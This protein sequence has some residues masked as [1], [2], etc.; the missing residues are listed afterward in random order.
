MRGNNSDA[1]HVRTGVTGLTA[2]LAPSRA[3]IAYEPTLS[4]PRDRPP[5]NA[6]S[7]RGSRRLKSNSLNHFMVGNPTQKCQVPLSL[8]FYTVKYGAFYNVHLTLELVGGER[9]LIR[10][11]P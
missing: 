7:G 9:K 5:Q 2:G 4:D 6:D 8:A 11:C 1:A 3:P 10:H